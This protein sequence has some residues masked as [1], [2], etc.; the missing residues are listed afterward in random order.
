MPANTPGRLTAVGSVRARYWKEALEIFKAHPALG[1]G[2]AGYGTARLRYRT[3]NLDV[4]QA[5]GYIVQTL[6]DLGHRR[7]GDHAGA[8]D[9]LDGRRGALHPPFNRRWRAKR[10]PPSVAWRN[11]PVAYTPE[12]IGMLAMLCIVIVF[13]V[14]SFA[15]WTWYVPGDA[16]V[17]LLCAGWL[18]GRGP[19]PAGRLGVPA[20]SPAAA[21]PLDAL[22]LDQSSESTAGTATLLRASRPRSPRR[23]PHVYA[24]LPR[25]RSGRCASAWRSPSSPG[26][27]SQPGRSGSHSALSKPPNRRSR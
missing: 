21:L 18:A 26:R 25:G 17:A 12:R 27:C 2:A 10:S 24:G 14:H 22:A 6:A 3:Q 7:P 19:L 4:R 1:A 15:D 9:R 23:T 20:G 5:H 16:F 11:E 13:G 8:A